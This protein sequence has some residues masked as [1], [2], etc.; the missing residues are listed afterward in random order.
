[1][2]KFPRTDGKIEAIVVFGDELAI[3]ESYCR[4]KFPP[5]PSGIFLTSV[6]AADIFSFI[7]LIT[8]PL[9]FNGY[10][11]LSIS[12]AALSNAIICVRRLDNPVKND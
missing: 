8:V 2:L 7:Y 11:F 3:G 5:L 4:L 9:L 12:V 6:F 10:I 1:M